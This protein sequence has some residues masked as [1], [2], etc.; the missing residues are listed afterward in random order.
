MKRKII[1]GLKKVGVVAAVVAGTASTSHA[2]FIT[3][4][5]TLD[6]TDM[7]FIMTGVVAGLGLMWT[8]RK[9][10]KTMNRS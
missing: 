2:A 9:V 10:I 6:T 3:E 4:A 8:A 5:V 7:G 1:N